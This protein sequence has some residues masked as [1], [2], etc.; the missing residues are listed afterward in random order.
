MKTKSIIIFLVFSTIIETFSITFSLL[1]GNIYSLENLNPQVIMII[2]VN[3]V[4]MIIC[5]LSNIGLL[6]IKSNN[7]K[8]KLLFSSILM[9]VVLILL[10]SIL[11]LASS[12]DLSKINHTK[13][14]ILFYYLVTNT[15]VI[16]IWFYEINLLKLEAKKYNYI[17]LIAL[18]FWVINAIFLIFDFLFNICYSID[19]S[20][21]MSQTNLIFILAIYPAISYIISMIILIKNKPPVKKIIPFVFFVTL[22]TISHLFRIFTSL[23][24][25][26]LFILISVIMMFLV[27]YIN[28]NQDLIEKDLEIKNQKLSIT[29]SQ[30]EPHFLFNSLQAIM[31]IDDCG[32]K[33][34]EAIADFGDYL[35]GNLNLLI[36][37]IT[38]LYPFSYSPPKAIVNPAFFSCSIE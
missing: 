3:I 7:Y 27:D 17:T 8:K 12:T 32:K 22:P 35:R 6:I 38:Y 4:S 5:L 24:T 16:F 19:E 11:V 21:K 9:I 10:F 34:R 1:I 18:I 26:Y 25:T 13:I 31:G 15:M 37:G 36:P 29:Y 30:I 33:T 28:Q 20:G 23:P 2:S 14:Y